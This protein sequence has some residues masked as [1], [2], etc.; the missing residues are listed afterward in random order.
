MMTT[1]GASTAP[2]PSPP[3]SPA[4]TSPGCP[5]CGHQPKRR[6]WLGSTRYLGQQF[7]YAEC[8]ACR[9][10]Y[11]DPMPDE[12]TVAQMYGTSYST[13]CGTDVDLDD[14]RQPNQVTGWLGREATGG[15]AG[16][17][18]DYGC[19]DGRLL[20]QAKALGWKAVGLELDPAVAQATAAR[21]GT[22]V[23]A[24][25]RQLRERHLADVLHLGDVIEHLTDLA[26]QMPEILTALKPGGLL[27]AQGPLEANTNLFTLALR[28]QRVLRGSPPASY[29]PYH[30]LLAT[31][32][33]QRTFF[34]RAGLVEL[35]Y[36]IDEV[37]WPAPPRLTRTQLRQPRAL[38]MFTLRRASQL[39]SALR[40][41][42]WGNRY[43][44]AG[45]R[46]LRGSGD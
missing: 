23:V 35:E 1:A 42:A 7:D 12:R 29:A 46:P 5:L 33:G 20:R 22:E 11:C 34:R 18:V 24:D 41:N 2:R 19:G 17:F 8:L 10:L 13:G 40:P 4:R 16:T 36:K 3:D 43:F 9:S 26:H 27:L 15:A 39:V 14:P 30:V 6:S 44:Y 37:A 38:A 45:R 25:P 28:G 21:T 32:E 31:A